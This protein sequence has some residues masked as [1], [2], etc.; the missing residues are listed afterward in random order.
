VGADAGSQNAPWDY[1]FSMVRRIVPASVITGGLIAALIF[2]VC[3]AS[4]FCDAVD[5][6]P[7]VARNV[8]PGAPCDSQTVFVFGLDFKPETY[9]CSAT[10]VWV[11]AGPLVGLREVALPC[12]VVNDSAQ[13]PDGSPLRCAQVNATLRWVFR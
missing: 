11:P 4:A 2:P 5:C 7:N 12:D 10:G 13:Q 1:C 6:V 9:A 3:R 8:I